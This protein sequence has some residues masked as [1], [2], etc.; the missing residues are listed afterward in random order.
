MTPEQ[1]KDLVRLE[2]DRFRGQGKTLVW[3]SDLVNNQ[4]E[5]FL[6]VDSSGHECSPYLGSMCWWMLNRLP[7]ADLEF[8]VVGSP[9]NMREEYVCK[10]DPSESAQFKGIGTTREESVINA[11]INWLE[12]RQETKS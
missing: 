9:G 2:P 1:I 7:G 3:T 8:S 10:P 4:S 6:V 5:D 11:Y 12:S